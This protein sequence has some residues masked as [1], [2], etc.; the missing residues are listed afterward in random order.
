MV[1][2]LLLSL[3]LLLLFSLLLSWF[4]LLLLLV[5]VLVFLVLLLGVVVA[6]YGCCCCCSCWYCRV[7]RRDHRRLNHL[8]CFAMARAFCRFVL[9]KPLQSYTC[10][11]RDLTCLARNF[12]N[13]AQLDFRYDRVPGVGLLLYIKP[14]LNISVSVCARVLLVSSLW[15]G[16]GKGWGSEFGHV[17]AGKFSLNSLSKGSRCGSWR[18]AFHW[19]G[20]SR[21][22]GVSSGWSTGSGTSVVLGVAVI[23]V[24]VAVKVVVVMVLAMVVV[25]V[26]GGWGGRGLGWG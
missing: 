11:L 1:G 12:A 17:R 22:G 24:A 23:V 26:G 15:P 2:L 9:P 13:L 10:H 5:L 3:F 16:F 8:P 18:T 20:S 25:V 4:S 14:E 19:Q 6:D 21:V 7:C